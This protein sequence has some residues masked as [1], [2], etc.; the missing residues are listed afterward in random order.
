MLEAL[1]DDEP[2]S[3]EL[4]RA[5]GFV[6]RSNF[7]RNHLTPALKA[8]VIERTIPGKPNSKLQKYRRTK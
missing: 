8:G 2:S 6:E 1:G 5:M 4:M 7:Q 3:V